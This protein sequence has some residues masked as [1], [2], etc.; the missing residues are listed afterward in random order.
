MIVP[1]AARPAPVDVPAVPWKGL[2]HSLRE[3]KE[4]RMSGRI[5]ALSGIA[6]LIAPP[7]ASRLARPISKLVCPRWGHGVHGIA[8][9]PHAG[10]ASTER[11]AHTIGLR[12]WAGKPPCPSKRSIY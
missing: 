12:A 9:P 10:L 2:R 6:T 1:P 11:V 4:E 7:S 5:C 3:C 8:D